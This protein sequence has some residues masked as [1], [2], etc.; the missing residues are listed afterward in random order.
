[1]VM[2][3]D[4]L[5]SWSAP[6]LCEAL[7]G[8]W[9]GG[10]AKRTDARGV[11]DAGAMGDTNPRL[12]LPQRKNYG[13]SESIG[14]HT[15]HGRETSTDMTILTFS[16]PEIQRLFG[17]EAAEDEDTDRLREYYFKSPVFEKITAPLP[18][19]ILVG[20]KG[21]GKS[22]LFRIALDDDKHQ[23]RLPIL[24]RPDD[25]EGIGTEARD[26][27]Q[28]IR[29]WKTGLQAII[30]AKIVESI[31]IDDGGVVSKVRAATTRFVALARQLLKPLLEKSVDLT[32]L[33]KVAIDA[34]LGGSAINVYLDDLDRGWEGRREDVLRISA[35]LNAVRDLAKENDGIQFRIALRS[36]VYYLVRT[37]DES[38]DKIEGSVIWHTW[39]NHE[40]L[41][42][43]VK[44]IE[45]FLGH[46]IDEQHLLS[47]R[48]AD[49]AV[50]LSPVMQERFMGHGHWANV[51]M[52]RVLMSLIRKRPRDLVKLLTL[53]AR[54]AHDDHS[55]RI[56]TDH[57]NSIFEEYSQGRVQDTVNEFRSE[58]PDLERLLLNMKPNK[59][60]RRG[61]SGYIY[62][63]DSLLEKLRSIAQMG[64]FRTVAGKVLDPKGLAAFMYKINFITARKE[65]EDDLI[66]R[67][68]FEENRYLSSTFADFGFDW[69]VH[70]AYR[71]ALQPDAGK[72][73]FEQL[74]LSRD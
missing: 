29:D 71:W 10:A 55:G 31:G 41:V 34:F 25:V 16:E 42:V 39:D 43:L 67:R 50:Y 5:D 66:E 64:A 49:L 38:T 59:S 52:Y 72:D 32:P 30:A 2:P 11:A 33:R 4:N 22:A 44:R 19:R 24:I 57:L 46:A 60:E 27:L 45:T 68:Y 23:G 47:L 18:L 63:T 53:A 9:W 15:I 20:H 74:R 58:V 36:D 12:S 70:P 51:P 65:R 35:L 62:T 21:V 69:E 54:R 37:S 7:R 48:Q 8:R 1:L 3:L 28:R 14:R 17:H 61:R 13:V 56:G 40:I 6:S 73:V 26:F